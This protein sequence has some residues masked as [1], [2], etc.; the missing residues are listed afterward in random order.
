MEVGSKETD[1]C[2]ND[3]FVLKDER[4][5]LETFKN[6]NIQLAIISSGFNQKWRIIKENKDKTHELRK[7][8]VW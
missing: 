2:S 6:I 3:S 8:F 4:G 7:V 1:K 5:N